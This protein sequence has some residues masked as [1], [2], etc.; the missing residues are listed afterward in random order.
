MAQ[1]LPP[2][3]CPDLW[4]L[5]P[6]L[7]QQ[8]VGLGSL[9]PT[10]VTCA[11]C[12]PWSPVTCR[13][14]AHCP[15]TGNSSTSRAGGEVLCSRFRGQDTPGTCDQSSLHPRQGPPT[16]G[17][18]SSAG[19]ALPTWGWALSTGLPTSQRILADGAEHSRLGLSIFVF[20][21]LAQVFI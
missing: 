1:S 3:G 7:A 15:C 17:P 14:P 10:R 20:K 4:P 5:A 11:S 6:G 8:W 16:R 19:L 18:P 13:M 12:L 21:D 2:E 9:L